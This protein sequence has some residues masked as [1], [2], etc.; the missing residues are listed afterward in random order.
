M[1]ACQTFSL[2]TAFSSLLGFNKKLKGKQ[3]VA[4]LQPVAIS[5]SCLV[6]YKMIDEDFIS[7]SKQNKL[8]SGKV[9]K[10]ITVILSEGGRCYLEKQTMQ[11]KC[12]D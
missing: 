2:P 10:L 12:N 5:V 7:S 11:S 1:W 3:L 8:D 4:E 9:K 6:P